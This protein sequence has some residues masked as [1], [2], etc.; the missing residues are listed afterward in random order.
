[1]RVYFHP[2]F[3]IFIVPQSTLKYSIL[4]GRIPFMILPFYGI[5]YLRILSYNAYLFSN[6]F[7]KRPYS[8]SFSA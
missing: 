6:A 1:M 4:R 5:K 7:N 8:G 2:L 3:A